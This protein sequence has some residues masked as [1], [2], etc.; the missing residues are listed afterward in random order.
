MMCMVSIEP[1]AFTLHGGSLWADESETLKVA[2]PTLRAA[3][4][5]TAWEARNPSNVVRAEFRERATLVFRNEQGVAILFET[6]RTPDSPSGGEESREVELH[7]FDFAS[8]G[9]A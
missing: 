6:F 3:V 9:E 4:V 2:W 5:G 1:I 7:W 8:E